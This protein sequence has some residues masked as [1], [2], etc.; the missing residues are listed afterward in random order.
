MKR[1]FAWLVVVLIALIVGVVA[2]YIRGLNY[3]VSLDEKVNEAWAQVET[4]LQRRYDLIPNL[5]NTVKGYASHEKELFTKITELRSQWAKAQTREE[6]I[7]KA[8]ELERALSRL[9]LV[10]ENYPD[11]KASQNF[12]TLQAQLEGTEN[13]IAVA[14]MRYN[15]AVRQFNT[16]IRTVFGSFF[17]KRRGLTKPYPYFKA[18]EKAAEAPVVKF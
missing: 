1:G 11:L 14:R 3:V 8:G 9:L 13:R 4:Q 6:K 16:Y 15:Q 17:A 18:E 12:L 2:W 10:A 7:E 5:V